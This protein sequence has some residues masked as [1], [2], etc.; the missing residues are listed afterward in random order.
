MKANAAEIDSLAHAILRVVD[1]E[2]GPGGCCV[3]C[4][5]RYGTRSRMVGSAV[6]LHVADAVVHR[7][8]A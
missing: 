3:H 8:L 1:A 2:Q 6:K 7:M 4:P 5:R